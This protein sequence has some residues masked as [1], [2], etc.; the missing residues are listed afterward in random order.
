MI[1][2]ERLRLLPWEE[3]DWAGF[4]PIAQ[5]PEVMRFINR[6]EPWS[7]ERIRQF[8]AKQRTLFTDH[9]F[10]RWR[11]ELKETGETVGFCGAGNVHGLEEWELGWWVARRYWGQGL[12][13][14]AA[15]AAINHFF[16]CTGRPKVVSV[17]AIGNRASERVAEKLGYAP[18]RDQELLGFQVRIYERLRS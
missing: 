3:E 13:T 18:I 10:C 17:I 7:D 6:G 11:L 12:A 4:A 16:Q 1:E 9:G 15:R 5:D 8:I 2:T 14:E